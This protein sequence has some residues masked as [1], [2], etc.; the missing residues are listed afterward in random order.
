LLLSETALAV[1]PK[2]AVG[3]S[4][5]QHKKRIREGTVRGFR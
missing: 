3:H 5:N 1:S 4:A 2:T